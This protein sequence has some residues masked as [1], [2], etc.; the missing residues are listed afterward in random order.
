MIRL[1][2]LLKSFF[3]IR[4]H[5]FKK[6]RKL[7]KQASQLL[8]DKT[9]TV[10]LVLLLAYTFASMFIFSDTTAMYKDYFIFLEQQAEDVLW[11]LTIVLPVRSMF[12]AFREPGVLYSSAEYQ[13]ALLPYPRGSIWLLTLL[14]RWLKR[15]LIYSIIAGVALLL[16]PLSLSFILTFVA[17]FV[18]FDIIMAIPQWKLFQQHFAKK[19][20]LF[21]LAV[22]LVGIASLLNPLL[23]PKLIAS[24][25]IS[26]IVLVNL[27]LLPHVFSHINWSKVTEINDYTIWRM[28]L[29]AFASKTKFKRP[30]RYT[31]FQNS[32]KNK[33]PFT[34]EGQ[35]YNRLWKIYFIKQQAIIFRALGT[36]FVLIAVLF[37]VPVWLFYIGIAVMLYVYISIAVSFYADRFSNDVIEVLP[38]STKNYANYFSQWMRL[39]AMLLFIPVLFFYFM[40]LSWWTPLYILLF[41][42]TYRCVKE[43]KLMKMAHSLTRK[44]SVLQ[45]EETIGTVAMI[46]LSLSGIYPFLTVSSLVLLFLIYKRSSKRHLFMTRGG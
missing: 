6:K 13:L 10:Y 24:L 19:M 34:T 26:C 39:G 8:F 4:V 46:C 45:V 27:F 42:T 43:V 23:E 38:W 35:I 18:M 14:E 41:W 11:V 22:V 37:F 17:T 16:T 32:S 28:P 33:L 30:K 40:H 2:P 29:L 44:K 36:L 5:R 1:P 21:L 25:L 9:T 12:H 20:M 15:L 7:N 3:F 31:L